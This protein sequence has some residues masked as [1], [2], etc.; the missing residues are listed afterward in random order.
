MILDRS[1]NVQVVGMFIFLAFTEKDV[2]KDKRAGF[3]AE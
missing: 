1:I 3:K 2:V